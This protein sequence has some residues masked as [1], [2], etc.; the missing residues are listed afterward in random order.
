[1]YAFRPPLPSNCFNSARVN[2]SSA[3]LEELDAGADETELVGTEEI[4]LDV[5]C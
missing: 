2:S 1:M 4:E 3:E 5:I